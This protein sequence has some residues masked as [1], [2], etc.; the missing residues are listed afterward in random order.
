MHRSKRTDRLLALFGLCVVLLSTSACGGSTD[1]VAP[2]T[3]AAVFTPLSS[4]PASGTISMQPG[5]AAGLAFQIRVAVKDIS[6]IFGAAFRVTF[7]P[8]VVRFD[9]A[10]FSTSVVKGSGINTQLSAAPVL[11][12]PSEIAVVAT[13]IQ[14]AA[15]TVAGVNVTDGELVV[16]HFHAIGATAG[17]AINFGTPREA[18]NPTARTCGPV[19]PVPTWIGGTLSAN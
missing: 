19:T 12:H 18:C 15:G 17:T 14:N 2:S 7:N 6:N 4:P 11:G 8:N 3:S 16:L 13:R 1:D 9:S 5:S 10:D